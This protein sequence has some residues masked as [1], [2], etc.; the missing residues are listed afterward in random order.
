M[1]SLF[2]VDDSI[3]IKKLLQNCSNCQNQ[4]K[5]LVNSSE[6]DE[7]RLNT[8]ICLL[9]GCPSINLLPEISDTEE[10]ISV[11][12]SIPEI[13]IDT[14]FLIIKGLKNNKYIRCI[15]PWLPSDIVAEFLCS[16]LNQSTNLTPL[17]LALCF[18][19]FYCLMYSSQHDDISGDTVSKNI[20]SYVKYLQ[21]YEKAVCDQ[22][23][24][25]IYVL[26]KYL[27]CKT[28]EEPSTCSLGLKFKNLKMGSCKS[29]ELLYKSYVQ[30]S[31]PLLS[32]ILNK[33]SLCISSD[34][35]ISWY[36]LKAPSIAMFCDEKIDIDDEKTIE[37]SIQT[38]IA[39]RVFRI[40]K[41]KN[42]FDNFDDILNLN[43]N[44]ELGNFLNQVAVD[45]DYD[46]DIELSTLELIDAIRQGSDNK[47]KKLMTLL[48]NR[49]IFEFKES[50]SC[51]E[52]HMS[53][54]TRSTA[55]LFIKRFIKEAK[56]VNKPDEWKCI[57]ID[58]SKRVTNY[59]VVNILKEDLNNGHD[60]VMKTSLFSSEF[61]Q[62]SNQLSHQADTEC[63]NS[64]LR[65]C[66]QSGVNVLKYSID[67]VISLSGLSPV[68]ASAF[69]IVNFIC[70][71]KGKNGICLTTNL[72]MEK[73]NEGLSLEME[74]E[75]FAFILELLDKSGEDSL[76]S[77]LHESLDVSSSYQNLPVD[78]NEIFEHLV[79]SRLKMEKE[80]EANIS[81]LNLLKVL[82][83]IIQLY[84]DV[85]LKPKVRLSC[86]ASL[87]ILH[88]NCCYLDSNNY[89][90]CVKIRNSIEEI[91]YTLKQFIVRDI[92]SYEEEFAL[93]KVCMG[94]YD[95]HC[96]SILLLSKF[97]GEKITQDSNAVVDHIFNCIWKKNQNEDE[98]TI[99]SC[100]RVEWIWALYI[101]FADEK[102]QNE[103]NKFFLFA[104]LFV[105]WCK[106][107]RAFDCSPEYPLPLCIV[108]YIEVKIQ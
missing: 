97:I 60:D 36:D 65:L 80:D 21:N 68:F 57:V 74:S 86:V 29:D 72:L 64:Y 73:F 78:V 50:L 12:K 77:D 54:V 76:S 103:E 13:N 39:H 98:I 17:S 44:K 32:Q 91:I 92:G 67:K 61:T 48:L 3:Q 51:L 59:D 4:V 79:C 14:F 41:M 71:S 66:L 33:L 55:L 28:V 56:D 100:S 24:S 58:L 102:L 31:I 96:R 84:S 20:E 43:A 30:E 42:K 40:M 19:M 37:N 15:F 107:Q 95:L 38:Q 108:I 69:R 6:F 2:T 85:I 99:P 47:R 1:V 11:I 70:R 94:R 46:S 90:L 7:F 49:E 88:N 63:F 26:I 83:K 23:T 45:P 106:A 16:F 34:I 18:E 5:S 62:I 104:N 93:L 10:L 22:P 25:N 101:K 53:F 9:L 87:I 35:W 52:E 8:T 27:D 82:K 75:L 81:L 105:W 89:N